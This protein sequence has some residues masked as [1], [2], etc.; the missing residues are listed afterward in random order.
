MSNAGLK[1]AGFLKD[2]GSS[3]CVVVPHDSEYI[4][5][6]EGAGVEVKTGDVGDFNLMAIIG[7]HEF[8][9]VILPSEDDFFNLNAALYALES[10]PNIRIVIRL[11]NLT[12]GKKL[13]NLV[14]N[15]TVL[16]V[17]HIS[18]PSF[19][20]AALIKKPL[21]SFEAGN[22]ILNFYS[23]MSD[24]FS[25]RAVSDIEK[26]FRLK[27]ISVNDEICFDEGRI[28]RPDDMLT[29]FSEFSDAATLCGIG[30][31][32]PETKT[33]SGSE[34]K[35]AG[36]FDAV[37]RIDK[38]LLYTIIAIIA[39]AFFCMFFFSRSEHLRAIDAVYF[40]ITVITTTGFGDISLKD[41]SDAAKIVG[42]FLMISGMAL[43]AML[44]AIIAD[45]LLKKRVDLLFGRKRMRLHN[46][47]VLCGIGDVGIRILEN[48]I[49]LG[50]KVVVIEKDENGR[51]LPQV[52]Q[53]NIP[54]MIADS[55]REETLRN[56]DI[57]HAKAI[58][59]ATN[60]DMR[61]LEIG[62]NASG[63]NPGVHIVLRIYEK[64]FAD[65]IEK[66]FGID[67]ALSSSSIAAPAFAFASGNTGA[68]G[69][70]PVGSGQVAIRKADVD[71]PEDL[72]AICR[73][74]SIKNLMLV[75]PDGE[76][77]FDGIDDRIIAGSVLYYFSV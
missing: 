17:S 7:L 60:N 14:G 24:K 63:I 12:L 19:A 49:K 46:H 3:V 77:F 32:D 66:H 34:E 58:I 37:R 67:V 13:E 26:E 6:L 52:R 35:R 28:I 55:T 74:G 54:L 69:S 70:V 38:I 57:R 42:I 25:G 20:S 71:S 51:N 61:N 45:S 22:F 40:V 44:F 59:C 33:K 16:S 31:K 15:F 29:V 4:R 50:E 73:T 2:S 75:T 48:L 1:I 9:S 5:K 62:L 43:M 41:S 53:K 72:A 30:C 68:I 27:V 56:A 18:S 64:D 23:L 36:L 8:S 76:I 65:K 47:I 11:F 10:R 21:L 39:V